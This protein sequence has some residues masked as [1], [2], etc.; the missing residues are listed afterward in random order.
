M[1]LGIPLAIPLT[2]CLL[3][4]PSVRAPV[5]Q[6]LARTDPFIQL[7]TWGDFLPIAQTKFGVRIRTVQGTSD[8]YLSRDTETEKRLASMPKLAL[9]DRLQFEL[10]R[11][12]CNQLDIPEKEF[13]VDIPW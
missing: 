8:H 5:E 2:G 3:Y 6:I 10:I 1:M 11:S 7:P 9:G 4:Q 12:L 13:G